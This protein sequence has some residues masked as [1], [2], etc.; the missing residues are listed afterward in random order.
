[1][2][3]S[4]TGSTD[5]SHNTFKYLG[6]RENVRKM[7]VKNW[8]LSMLVRTSSRPDMPMMA[9]TIVTVLGQEG[10]K[11]DVKVSNIYLCYYNIYLY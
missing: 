10:M 4:S 6:T 1:M 9:R 7:S 5:S 11:V 3:L 8:A 2:V